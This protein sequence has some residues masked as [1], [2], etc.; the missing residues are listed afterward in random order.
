M[1][2]F[3]PQPKNVTIDNLFEDTKKHFLSEENVEII[4][5]NPNYIQIITDENYLKTIIRNLT[6][7]AIK[8]LSDVENPT[9]IW[10]VW[11]ENNTTY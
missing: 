1:K 4:F 3:K 8:A 6:G 11:Q 7:N 9:I 5:E 10:K 2:N